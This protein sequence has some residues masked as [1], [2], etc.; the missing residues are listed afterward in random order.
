MSLDQW[1]SQLRRRARRWW[2]L[3]AVSLLAVAGCAG[4]PSA[5]VIQPITVISTGDDTIP[6]GDGDPSNA[7][8]RMVLNDSISCI[9]APPTTVR[10]AYEMLADEMA[11]PI[12]LDAEAGRLADQAAPV[13]VQLFE[14]KVGAVLAAVGRHA[15]LGYTLEGGRVMIRPAEKLAIH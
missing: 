15:K 12:E 13:Q 8:I 10:E 9:F 4:E 3:F 5:P 7:P 6:E 2:G 14:A 1:L 11:I